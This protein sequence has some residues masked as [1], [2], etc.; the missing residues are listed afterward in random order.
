MIADRTSNS[1]SD[2]HHPEDWLEHF[3]QCRASGCRG[4]HP[5]TRDELMLA[6]SVGLLE[7]H[8]EWI[9]CKIGLRL[10]GLPPWFGR[11][12]DPL[13]PAWQERFLQTFVDDQDLRSAFRL[14]LNNEVAV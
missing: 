14:L 1:R 9:P 3:E 12:L 13:S 5:A 11:K 10:L 4:W 7:S 8:P 2:F 6:E